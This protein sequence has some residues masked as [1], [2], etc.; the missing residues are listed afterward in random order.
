MHIRLSLTMVFITCLLIS[1]CQS[2]PD[3][4][5]TVTYPQNGAVITISEG[6][7]P[8]SWQ[9]SPG[10]ITFTAETI[11]H[12]NDS[13]CPYPSV[14]IEPRDNGES[15]I[16]TPLT[17]ISGNLCSSTASSQTQ[18]WTWRPQALGLHQLSAHIIVLTD[19][20]ATREFDSD[21]VTV[22]VVGD[23]LH[24]PQNVPMGLTSP[25]CNPLIPPTFTPIPTATAT[26]VTPIP[27]LRNPNQHGTGCGQYSNQTRCN[28]AGCAWNPQTSRCSVNP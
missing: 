11:P 14:I 25:D 10:Y 4:H 9:W 20:G 18:S 3:P 8:Y 15:F 2:L 24:P 1:G 19:T 17:S 27:I 7:R 5:I 22:C 13:S 28:L 16:G 23:P 12:T 26:P 6:T 21:S